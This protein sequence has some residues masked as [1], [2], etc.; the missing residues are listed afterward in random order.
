MTCAFLCLL[1]TSQAAQAS[2]MMPS[3][4]VTRDQ[5]HFLICDYPGSHLASTRA[6]TKGPVP[7]G[8]ATWTCERRGTADSFQV[9]FRVISGTAKA[10]GV[11]VAFD[12]ADW[13]AKNYVLVPAAVYNGNR[14]HALE[15][16]YM[17]PY[18]RSMFFDP[19]LPVT[20][21]N[22]P[23]L[24]LTPGKPSLIELLTGNASA[25]A[26]AFFSPV[27]K[28]GFIV[29][30][31]Q[32]SQFGNHELRIEENALQN[33]AS[34]IVSAPG[35][36]ERAAEFGG[37]RPSGDHG[38]DWNTGDELTLNFKTY[39]F[40]AN[41][42][43]DLL[44]K[45]LSVRKAL[46][47]QNQPRDLVPMSKMVE[48]VAPRFKKRWQEAPVGGYYLPENSPDFQLGWVSGFMQTPM[49]ALRD[50]IERA[51]VER[52]LDF[53]TDK[54]QGKSGI[55]Y[56]GITATG[57][58]R[59]DRALDNRD[60][61][62]TRKNADALVM[63]F[64][65]FQILQ[66]QGHGN[67]IKPKW[68]Q[69]ARR[70]A[71]AF[72]SL[73]KSH[74]EF[75]QYL[76]PKTGEIAVFNSTSGALVPAG[77]AMA[78]RYFHDPDL[79]RI[80]KESANFYYVRDVVGRGFT[81]GHCA[82]ISHDPDSESAFGFLE[83]LMALY[84]ATGDRAW[85]QKARTGAALA[86]TWVLAYDYKFPPQSDIGKLGSHMAGAV[87]AS[88][89]NKHA[90]PGICTSSGDYLFKLFRA[91]GDNRYA[92]LLRD[93]QHAHVEATDMPG[94]PTCRTGFGASMERIQPTDAEGKGSV[95]NFIQTQNAG[96][97]WAGS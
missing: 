95:G 15:G 23:R 19:A 52:Q 45:F 78:A 74:G 2:S 62:L 83:S 84:W 33:R 28:K 30:C 27:Q 10:Q 21:S 66:A 69:S 88:A 86:A 20:M 97:S 38:V 6:V 89:Q 77:L 68:V 61:V 48:T 8:T 82:D 65:F 3:P 51:H 87:W 9:T 35:V 18:P 75:G 60:F 31:E 79:L 25:P 12:F 93:I 85:L 17:P 37:F 34:F 90:A 42:I 94:H 44:E 67:E 13:N 72:A 29:L 56:G 5:V 49:L 41:S 59:A 80:A 11:A 1:A 24:E 64:K 55:F 47:G 58:I 46:T 81:G 36:R 53:V 57:K 54:L 71:V 76:D 63:F 26:M 14:L 92:D 96:A 73:W 70:L 16:G 40:A 7:V 43:P 39:T 32:K 22:N 50:P 91:T 4:A